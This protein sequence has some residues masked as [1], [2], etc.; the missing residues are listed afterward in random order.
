M[1]LTFQHI[2]VEMQEGCH[3]VRFRRSD[4]DEFLLRDAC[5]ELQALVHEHGCRRL[6]LALGPE[7]LRCMYSIFL[8]RL[9][10]LQRHLGEQGGHLLLCA[11]PEA[12]REIFAACKLDGFFHFLP[13][14]AAAA[15]G[16]TD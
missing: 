2:D 7:P 8:S 5:A 11:T 12:V 3:C 1:L 14:F 10:T 6:A 4:L 16:W 13:D 15:R 9:L